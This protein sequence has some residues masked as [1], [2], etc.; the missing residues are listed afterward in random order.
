MKR[1]RNS[2]HAFHD[3]DSGS[4]GSMFW[5]GDNNDGMN[6]LDSR[7]EGTDTYAQSALDRIEVI[8]NLGNVILT[9]VIEAA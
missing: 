2:N 7:G 1:F 6:V 3:I 5:N 9:D 8:E 4:S